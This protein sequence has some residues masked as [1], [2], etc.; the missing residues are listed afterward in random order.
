[1][2]AGVTDVAVVGAGLSGLICGRQLRRRGLAVQLLEARGR[3]GG[4]MHA[5]PTVAGLRLDLGGQWVGASHHR[6][7]ALLEEL[8][9]GRFPTHYNGEGIFHW[10]GRSHRA[11]IEPDYRA[12]LLFF[13]PGELGLD[14]AAVADP[15]ALQHPVL[16]LVAGVPADAPWQAAN[17]DRLDRLSVSGWL[18]HQQAG[19]LARYPFAWLTRLGGSGGFEPHESSLLHLAWTQAVAPQHETPEAWLVAGGIAQV[20]DRLAEEL[21]GDLRLGAAVTA[22]EQSGTG[23]RLHQAD[24]RRLD[25][26]AVVVAIPPPLRLA[27]HFSPALPARWR[28]LLQ[29]SPMGSMVKVLA[30]YPRPFWRERGLCG[31]GIGPLPTV[32]LTVDSSPTDGP[33]VLAG[34]IAGERAV[35]WRRLPEAGRRRAVL[36]DLECW[37]GAEA[38]APLALVLHD[39]NDEPWSGGAFT[40]FLTPGAWTTHRPQWREPHGR[41]VWAGTETARRWPGYFE[42]AIEA[43]LAAA[44]QVGQLLA[45]H[46]AG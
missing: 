20:A 21:A 11:A 4:R 9:L 5:G 13:Q 46:H 28:G 3:W 23:V 6:L 25:A 29:R 1:M 8:G 40:S 37:W 14:A 17:A 44:D 30:I 27:I 34:F 2:A 42:G 19:E 7:I 38:A 16:E 39:W 18:D 12:S 26:A 33:G 31:L 43:G 24:G 15:P 22:I 32:E 41:V 45:D 36:A 10:Q 35:R